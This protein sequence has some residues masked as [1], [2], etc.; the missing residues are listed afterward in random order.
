MKNEQD[1]FILFDKEDFTNWLKT[2]NIVREIKRIQ[3]HH[4]WKPDYSNFKGDDHFKLLSSMKNYHVNTNSWSD[5]AQNLTTFPDGTIAVCRPLYATPVGIK[6]ANT[7]GICIEHIGNFDIGKDVITDAHKN[8]IIYLNAVLCEKF[9]L[10]PDTN[11]IVYHHW[12]DLNTGERKNGEGK[13]KTCPGENFFG[14]NK[15]E[16]AKK[17]FIPLIVKNFNTLEHNEVYDD[18]TAVHGQV[19]ASKLN[20]RS[21]AGTDNNVIGSLENGSQI[22]IYEKKDGWF[23]IAKDNEW[24]S[25]K[26]IKVLD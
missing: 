25:D 22:K 18:K 10:E 16:D 1:S 21:G 6:G 3:N 20:V 2:Q 15:V 17:Y 19:T 9:N 4:T 8:T 14:G 13:T 5:I 23:R 7:R 26:Y 11:T 12:Y 24:V